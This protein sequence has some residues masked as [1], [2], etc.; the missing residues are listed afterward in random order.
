MIKVTGIPPGTSEDSLLFFF[1]NRRKSGGDSITD[2]EYD[3]DTQSAVITFEDPKAVK[4]VLA[5]IPILFSGVQIGVEEFQSNLEV[6]SADKEEVM[7]SENI[8]EVRGVSSRTTMDTVEMYFENTRRSGGG[9]I[10]SIDA[11]DG[12]FYIVF[13]D[14][15]VIENVLRKRQQIEGREVQ[16]CRHVPPPPSK[17][18]PM[19]PNKVFIKNISEDTDKYKL[20]S[21]LT[22]EFSLTLTRIEYGELMR[23]AIVTFDEDLDFE[24]LQMACKKRSLEKSYLEVSRVPITN[25]VILR[26][27][28][29]KTSRD[30]LEF[31]FDNERISGVTAGVLDIKLFDEFCLV[32]FEEPEVADV[33]SKRQH[34]VDRQDLD[35]KIYYECLGQVENDWEVPFRL[36]GPLE[37]TDLDVNK[38]KFLIKSPPDQQVM[39]KQLEAVYGKPVWPKQS[40]AVSLTVECTLTAETKDCRKLVRTWGTKVKEDLN[41]FLDLLNYGTYL[42]S[43]QHFVECPTCGSYSEFYCNNCHQRMCEKCKAK[44]LLDPDNQNHEITLYSDRKM[45]FWK[46][47]CKLHPT[48]LIDLCCNDC[49]K[50]VCSLCTTTEIHKGH[51]FL[52]LEK[53][54]TKHKTL[55]LKDIC[56]IRDDILPKSKDLLEDTKS[57]IVDMKKHL[58]NIRESM[59]EQAKN[60]KSLVDEV[61]SKNLQVLGNFEVSAIDGL[62]TQEETLSAYVSDMHRILEELQISISSFLPSDIM[63]YMKENGDISISPIPAG[64]IYPLPVFTKGLLCKEEIS[65]EFGF[66][67][68][69][70][71]GSS[72]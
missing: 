54:F 7:E 3:L 70:A 28:S 23:T 48:K 64:A 51:H 50:V 57:T 62:S 45:M 60:L 41:K 30:T 42:K 55:R 31:Y 53:V 59:Q 33:V 32:Y 34:R 68:I 24:K 66:L 52:D 5:K 56:R 38:L 37:F 36:P 35:V 63:K 46:E 16:V 29:K 71:H 27:V 1:E 25:C 9:D 26:N 20:E 22:E 49:Q 12:V 43:F 72:P 39:E 18:V 17:P 6:D 21:F 47:N 4:R 65:K 67:Q 15:S 40:K 10:K 44:H 69:E 61:L 19:Y 58:K 2:I 14:G 8:L 11:K 13:E